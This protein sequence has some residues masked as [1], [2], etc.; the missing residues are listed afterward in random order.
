MTVLCIN[1]SLGLISRDSC[2]KNFEDEVQIGGGGV[3]VIGSSYILIHFCC[4]VQQ[5]TFTVTWSSV[6]L[7]NSQLGWVGM[8]STV[9]F[10]F[11]KL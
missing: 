1:I 3:N 6:C 10:R 8:L 11:E 4:L 5:S 9:V 7:Y 2:A